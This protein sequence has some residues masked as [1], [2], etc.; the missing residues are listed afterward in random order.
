VVAG[1]L[2]AAFLKRQRAGAGAFLRGLVL[3]SALAALIVSPLVAYFAQHP[4]ELNA[5]VGQVS[6]LSGRDPV[7]QVG[8]SFLKTVGMFVWRGD[9][10]VYTNIPDRP[11]F[12]AIVAPFFLLGLVVAARRARR[13]PYALLLLWLAVMLLPGALAIGAPNFQRTAGL[14]PAIF[15]LPALGLATAAAWLAKRVRPAPPF[16]RRLP[17]LVVVLSAVLTAHAYFVELPR[18]PELWRWYETD[19]AAL[20]ERARDLPPDERIY[21]LLPSLPDVAQAEHQ[22]TTLTFLSGRQIRAF[23]P[24][25]FPIADTAR[26]PTTYLFP[27]PADEGARAALP[28]GREERFADPFSG[29]PLLALRIAAGASLRPE[30]AAGLRWPSGAHLIGWTLVRDDAA[31]GG[32]PAGAPTEAILF[33]EPMAGDAPG[34]TG[35]GRFSLT[36]HDGDGRHHD[37]V[38]VPLRALGCPFDDCRDVRAIA[39]RAYIPAPPPNAPPPYSLRLR[40]LGENG[41]SVEAIDEAGRRAGSTVRLARF[42]GT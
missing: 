42:D 10:W 26:R 29:R 28:A 16:V 7:R 1:T 35:A 32:R 21:A 15:V 2:L 6:L 17:A 31:A 30:Q 3:M 40:F 18:Q 37:I 33:W 39:R 38:R 12:D 19:V 36:L 11:V 4:D 22:H 25:I 14:M 23:E 34:E 5:R 8:E 20:A 13:P 41:S 27:G 24:N 9:P